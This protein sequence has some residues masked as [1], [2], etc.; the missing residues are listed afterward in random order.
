MKAELRKQI[1]PYF[2]EE[3]GCEGLSSEDIADC[4]GAEHFNVAV[5]VRK[6]SE[7]LQ[8]SIAT[9]RKITDGK[10]RNQIVYLLPVELAKMV[11]AKYDSAIGFAYL[12]FL[13]ECERVATELTP[14]LVERVKELELA[15]QNKE[16]ELDTA[17]KVR[18]IKKLAAPKTMCV[19]EIIS[20]QEGIFGEPVI[21]R[22]FK[23]V[24]IATL[25]KEEI[26]TAR[27]VNLT[28]QLEGVAKAA[29]ETLDELDF[30]RQQKHL[31]ESIQKYNEGLVVI[32]KHG[33]KPA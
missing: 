22:H 8:I 19:T 15:L 33:L 17:R 10:G 28:R 16:L 23:H 30:I 27:H 11:V 7:R 29:K 26:L 6:F 9:A 24:A 12:R 25:T 2:I 20:K 31:E 21:E 1:K 13:L 14:R 32:T 5:K 3:L 18:P 4:L